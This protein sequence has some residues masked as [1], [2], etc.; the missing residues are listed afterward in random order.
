MPV[1]DSADSTQVTVARRRGPGVSAGISL[2]QIVQTARKMGPQ[3]PTMQAIADELG[4]NR[5]AISHYVSD[6]EELLQLIAA[7][8]FARTFSRTSISPDATWQQ[9]THEF[10][11]GL[12]DSLVLTGALAFWVKFNSSM[13]LAVLIPSN[14]LL[15]KLFDAGFDVGDSGL[16]LTAVVNMTTAYARDVIVVTN[17]GLHRQS[18]DVQSVLEV[19]PNSIPALRRLQEYG[20]NIVSEDRFEFDLGLLVAGMGR[21]ATL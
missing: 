2:H 14:D 1:D 19:F 20:G 5:K 17:E 10:A 8:A 13:D 18:S 12:R 6:R 15:Q 3:V 7:D 9:A 21:S 4:V 16:F 11:V